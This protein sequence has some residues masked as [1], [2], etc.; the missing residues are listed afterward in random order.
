MK[1]LLSNKFYY[2]RG[3][4]C[5]YT[6]NVESLLKDR[7]CEVA[8]FAMQYPENLPS[9]YQQ[10]FPSETSYTNSSALL[11]TF[12]RPLGSREVKIKFNRLLDDFQPDIV[13]LNNIH[14]QLSPIIAQIA[15][16]KGVRVV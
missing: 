4:D 13:H 2:P 8:I 16:N 1:I 3:G 7:G 10:Y 9:A 6:L 12:K 11:E 14:S 15:H 5:I